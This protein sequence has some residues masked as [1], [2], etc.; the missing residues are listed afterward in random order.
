MELS[1]PS[2]LKTQSLQYSKDQGAKVHSTEE[3]QE[4]AAGR[5]LEIFVGSPESYVECVSE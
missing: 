5:A 4:K 2:E 1:R 3:R